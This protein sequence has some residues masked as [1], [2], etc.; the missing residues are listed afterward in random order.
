MV[1]IFLAFYSTDFDQLHGFQNIN[2]D[3]Y[4]VNNYNNKNSGEFDDIWCDFGET[5]YFLNDL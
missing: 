3:L 5:C 4:I 1:S 2:I